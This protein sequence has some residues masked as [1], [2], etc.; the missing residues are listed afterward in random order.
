LSPDGSIM[1]GQP[2]G[3]GD[4]PSL[5][6]AYGTW[7]LGGPIATQ[8]GYGGGTPCHVL[9][10]GKQTAPG[11]P[12]G[13]F[14]PA[15]QQLR[16]NYGG[17]LYNFSFDEIWTQWTGYSWNQNDGV[18]LASGPAATPTPPGL[19]TYNPPY[20]PSSE[21]STISGGTGTLQTADGVWTFGAANGT[22]W[23]VQLNGIPLLRGFGNGFWRVADQMKVY[24][25]G[26][27]FFHG[28][29]ATP[30]W[31]CWAGNQANA[32]TGPTASPVPVSLTVS[33]TVLSVPHLSSIGTHIC[34]V[35]VT[36][37]DGSSFTGSLAVDSTN[38]A[39]SGSSLVTAVTPI[40][41]EGPT[42]T[43]SQNGSEFKFITDIQVT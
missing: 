9:L 26:Q 28:V 40:D 5:R 18:D 29:D 23:Q 10:N 39:V 38:V 31:F 13:L 32:S 12:A 14:W 35:N 7:T 15:A 27:M 25:S 4:V 8:P 24:A 22:G 6:T 2:T 20:T 16:V 36:M 42:I 3:G 30:G 33:P 17:N 21:N 37:S 34:D 11:M 43:A 1:I 19:P 41:K